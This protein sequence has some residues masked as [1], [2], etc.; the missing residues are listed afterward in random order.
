MAEG[1]LGISSLWMN[2]ISVVSGSISSRAAY[3]SLGKPH[4]EP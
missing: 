1:E 4:S 2:K 3:A